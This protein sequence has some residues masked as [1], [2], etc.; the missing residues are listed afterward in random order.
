MMKIVS[1]KEKGYNRCYYRGRRR[2]VRGP[3][4]AVEGW[5]AFKKVG[6]MSYVIEARLLWIKPQEP[7]L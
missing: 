4:Q 1:V 2:M 6:R 7:L 3:D 5:K